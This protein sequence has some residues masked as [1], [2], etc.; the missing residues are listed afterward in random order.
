MILEMKDIKENSM[1]KENVNK[2][3]ELK[4]KL[5]LLLP[6]VQDEKIITII[7]WAKED[8]DEIIKITNNLIKN[9]IIEDDKIFKIQE[10]IDI[11]SDNSI[12]KNILNIYRAIENELNR[13]RFVE[14]EIKLREGS[15][16]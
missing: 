9:G 4:E 5:E 3:I 10:K 13:W 15:K 11:I 7:N 8:V 2:V 14:L 6:Y 12:E 1:K 16:F